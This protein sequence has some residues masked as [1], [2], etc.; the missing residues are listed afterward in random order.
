M[1]IEIKAWLYDIL[2]AIE[3]IENFFIN[4]PKVFADYQIDIRT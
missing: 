1:D 3:E 4:S 2:S